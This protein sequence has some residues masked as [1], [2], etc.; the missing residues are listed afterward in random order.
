M[1]LTVC[2]F[3]GCSTVTCGGHCPAHEKA[4]LETFPRGRPFASENQSLVFEPSALLPPKV[5][6][7]PSLDAPARIAP[8]RVVSFESAS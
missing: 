1:M 5:E 8:L 6:V 3:P 2:A 4:P 7:P